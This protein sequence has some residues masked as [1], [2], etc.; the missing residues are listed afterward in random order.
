LGFLGEKASALNGNHLEIAK[1]PSKEDDNYIRVASH[2]RDIVRAV[3][4]KEIE[5][6]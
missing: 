6:M 1:F 4:E 3:T 2:I 5:A